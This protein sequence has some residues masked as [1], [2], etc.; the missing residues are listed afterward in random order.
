MTHKHSCP[1]HINIY[2]VHDSAGLNVR[3]VTGHDAALAETLMAIQGHRVDEESGDPSMW[4]SV[5]AYCSPVGLRR[6]KKCRPVLP[7]VRLMNL[8]SVG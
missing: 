1:A 3:S 5:Q 4:R 8:G 7:T 6:S 2:E